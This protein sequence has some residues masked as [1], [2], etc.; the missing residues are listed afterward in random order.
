[1][2]VLHACEC[3]GTHA[4]MCAYGGL[5]K[6]AGFFAINVYLIALRQD[7]PV[8]RNF[9]DLAR[10]AGQQNSRICVFPPLGAGLT[11]MCIPG[12]FF[13]FFF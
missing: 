1:M 12:L 10:P 8:N 6:I 4:H 7:H 5:R 9:A 13:F 11:G 2:R 3:V